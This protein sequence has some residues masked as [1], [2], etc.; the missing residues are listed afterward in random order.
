MAGSAQTDVVVTV[1]TAASSAAA[2]RPRI[3]YG[4][5][6]PFIGIGVFGLIFAVPAK[7]RRASAVMLLIVLFGAIGLMPACGGVSTPAPPKSH[8]YTVTVTGTSGNVTHTTN[9]SLTVN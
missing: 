9:F 8:T 5:W 7:R 3:V 1:A 2:P 4:A 6:L